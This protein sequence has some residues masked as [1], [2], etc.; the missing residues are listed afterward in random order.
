MRRATQS[1]ILVAGAMVAALAIPSAGLAAKPLTCTIEG[2]PRD[3][4]IP[5]V[6]QGEVFCGG[7]GDDTVYWNLGTFVGGPGNDGVVGHNY[8]SGSLFIGG[9]GDDH[10]FWNEP[11]STF[12]GGDG[13]DSVTINYATFIGDEGDDHVVGNAYGS[14]DGGPGN[15][16]VDGNSEGTFAGGP[17]MDSVGTNNGTFTGGPD[18]DSVETAGDGSRFI[19]GP[20]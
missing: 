1:A 4:H 19:P 9:A 18:Y 2:T 6:S 11:G 12:D 10:V 7:E 17:G 14:V 20:Q 8:W 3:D 16:R 15:D 5:Q 13:A